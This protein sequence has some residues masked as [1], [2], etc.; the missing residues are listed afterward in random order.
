MVVF[1]KYLSAAVALAV[2]ESFNGAL[3]MVLISATADGLCSV[4]RW[5]Y[6]IVSYKGYILDTGSLT[7]RSLKVASLL[8]FCLYKC[9]DLPV[10]IKTS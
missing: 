8:T 2:A 7:V 3:G 4:S 1:S 6:F 5:A 10:T 9:R